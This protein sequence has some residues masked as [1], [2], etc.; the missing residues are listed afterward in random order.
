M[1]TLAIAK[2]LAGAALALAALGATGAAH[3]RVDWHIGINLPGPM[4]SYGPP[5]IY[6]PAPVYH[7]PPPVYYPPPPV[8]YPPP[9]VYGPAPI[10][11]QQAPVYAQPRHGHWHDR[12]Y[13]E[14]RHHRGHEKHRGYENRR[15]HDDDD[16]ERR[17]SRGGPDRYRY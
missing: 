3:A 12:G 11:Y 15:D 5:V 10:Y 17:G 4:V 14:Y 9:A 13:K 16:H 8:Y 7:A 1:S 2:T 6:A